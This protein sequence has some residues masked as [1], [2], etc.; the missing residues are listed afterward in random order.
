MAGPVTPAGVA[1]VF[2]LSVRGSPEFFA[3]GVLVHNCDALIYART[4]CLHY[5]VTPAAPPGPEWGTPEFVQAQ[6]DADEDEAANPQEDGG[7]DL[8]GFSVGEDWA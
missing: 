5:H 7:S 6:L 4:K 2:S 8:T 3:S 1:E